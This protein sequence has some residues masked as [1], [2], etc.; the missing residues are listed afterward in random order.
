MSDA[1]R[2]WSPEFIEVFVER[3]NDDPEFQRKARGFSETIILRCLDTPS[4]EDV[5]AA[6]AFEDGDVVGVDLWIDDAPSE[7]M[8]NDPFDKSEGMARATADYE[9]WCKL[10]R[11]E[12]GVMQAL[13]SPDYTIEG[14]KLRIMANIGVLN[15]MSDVA[16]KIE[17]TY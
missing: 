12:M 15:G 7:D 14:P 1:P 2:Y 5:E 4:D 11:G 17:K 16:A 10:D 3:M 13:A 8:R 9:T 6:Y